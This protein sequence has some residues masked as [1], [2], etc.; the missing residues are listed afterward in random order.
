MEQILFTLTG[1]VVHGKAKGSTVG[2][3]TAN[4]CV[5]EGTVLPEFGVYAVS[6]DIEGRHY[7]GITNV[8]FRPSVD[9]SNDITIETYIFDFSNNIYG[10]TISI[11]FHKY[12]RS[13]KKFDSLEKVKRQVEIDCSAVRLFF[14]ELFRE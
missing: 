2:M 5:P 6:I 10:K 12:I 3:P 14:S 7:Y 4:L 8:G 11:N 9:Q 1:V 13:T